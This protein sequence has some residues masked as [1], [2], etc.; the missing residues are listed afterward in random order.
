MLFYREFDTRPLEG[1]NYYRLVQIDL[2]GAIE[3]FNT[4][5]VKHTTQI[6]FANIYPNP[7]VGENVVIELP[8]E[9]KAEVVLNMFS[10][11]GE[12]VLTHNFYKD[13]GESQFRIPLGNLPNSTYIVN[14]TSRTDHFSLPL[15]VTR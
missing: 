4:I 13:K 6:E 15:V 8:T 7:T 10:V 2:D 12:L 9:L 1:D 5:H 14:I 3:I 11:S